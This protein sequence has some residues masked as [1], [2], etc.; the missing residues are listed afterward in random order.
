LLAGVEHQT[1]CLRHLANVVK[2]C[3]EFNRNA[4]R[5]GFAFV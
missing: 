5:K 3:G 4:H 1:A 2:L